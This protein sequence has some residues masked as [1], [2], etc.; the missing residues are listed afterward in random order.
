MPKLAWD[1][2]GE[3]YYETG[4]DKGVLY[5]YDNGYNKGVAWD[6]LTGFSE[7]PSGAEATKIYADN[8][9]YLT[10]TS[11]EELGGTITA[12]QSPEEFDECDGTK[13]IATGVKI[14]MQ[15]RKT[16]G[17]C[18]RTKLGNDTVGDEYG[19]KLH[20]I[21]G[22]K[23]SPSERAYATVNDSPEAMELSWEITTTPVDV[24]IEGK[25]FKPTAIITI[26]STEVDSEKLKKLEKILYGQDVAAFD[27]TK[28]YVVGD[29]VTHEDDDVVKTYKCKVAVETAGAW[30]ATDWEETTEDIARLPLP[31]EVAEIFAEG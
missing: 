27:E 19:Y 30:D 16:F 9:Q 31:A 23:A 26:N 29:L 5:P 14:G 3:R 17:F 22:C 7:S 25:T 11:A 4:V 12:Y 18:Y 8:I 2:V 1:A 15:T 6:G 20:L 28:T 24:N 13:A 10:M 21:Y